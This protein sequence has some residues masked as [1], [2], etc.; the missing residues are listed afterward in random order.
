MLENLKNVPFVEKVVVP[1][2]TLENPDIYMGMGFF[3]SDCS[4]CCGLG[5][6]FL[7]MLKMAEETRQQLSA[8]SA[9]LFLMNKPFG[10]DII[11]VSEE[12]KFVT[13][14]LDSLGM[15]D[16]RIVKYSD[17]FADENLG[18]S[19]EEVQSNITNRLLPD[20]GFQIGWVYPYYKTNFLAKDE[21]YF[22]YHFKKFFPQR[23]DI[24]FVLGKFPGMIPNYVPGP[25]YLVKRTTADCR[26]LLVED[27]DSLSAKFL[28]RGKGG[29]VKTAKIKRNTLKP[30][31][32]IFSAMGFHLNGSP[33]IETFIECMQQLDQ[34]IGDQYRQVFS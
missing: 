32:D 22:S 29:T 33:P 26:V 13:F 19:Y 21:H 12:E 14:F 4:K 31:F 23:N 1:E 15:K 17:L 24:G 5:L 28:V 2:C 34:L 3:G 11:D 27:A 9:T 8:R 25:P 6:D 20:G 30:A 16:W 18:W 10:Q 7:F